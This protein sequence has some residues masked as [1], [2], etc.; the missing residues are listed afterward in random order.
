MFGTDI[1]AF[2]WNDFAVGGNKPAQSL[3]VFVV[4]VI[5]VVD[6]EVTIFLLG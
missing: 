3:A 2:A 1:A 5:N 6:A 4:N